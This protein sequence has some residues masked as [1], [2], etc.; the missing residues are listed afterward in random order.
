MHSFLFFSL[1]FERMSQCAF[2]RNVR[3]DSAV[4]DH[5]EA[6]LLFLQ[7]SPPQTPEQ[8]KSANQIQQIHASAQTKARYAEDMMSGS[9]PS[10]DVYERVEEH[11]KEAVENYYLLG[12]LLAMPE[13][14]N[15]ALNPP[16]LPATPPLSPP[17]S[18]F[19]SPSPNQFALQN[20]QLELQNS[21]TG[22]FAQS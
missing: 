11:V 13:L 4:R 3:S 2:S 21:M 16:R 5:T 22:A 20:G 7:D 14:A 19:Y 1:N 15:K 9:N 17:S 18:P 10:R 12:Q 6:A 8:T